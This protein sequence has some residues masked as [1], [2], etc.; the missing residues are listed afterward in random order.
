MPSTRI[1][2]SYAASAAP[3]LRPSTQKL[4][5]YNNTIEDVL[6]KNLREDLDDVIAYIFPLSADLARMQNFLDRYLNFPGGVGLDDAPPVYF[7]PAAPFVLLEVANYGRLSSN[8]VNA[9]WFSQREIAFG[10][11]VEWY[12]RQG[13][14]ITFLK[15]ALIYPYVYVDSPLGI[16]GGRQIYGWSKAPVEVALLRHDGENSVPVPLAPVFSPPGEQLLLAA[17]LLIPGRAPEA[18]DSRRRLIEIRQ[19][20]YLQ[21]ASSLVSDIL[22]AL[23]RAIGASLTTSWE[24]L[25]FILGSG[26]YVSSQIGSLATVLPQYGRL[27]AQF[28]PCWVT[29]TRAFSPDQVQEGTPT[30]IITFKQVRDIDDERKHLY[31]RAC[32]QGIVESQMLIKSITAGGSLVDATNPDPAAGIYIDL[33]ERE[34]GAGPLELGMHYQL[35]DRAP[36]MAKPMAD[37]LRRCRIVPFLPFWVKMNLR[38]G[39]AN[40]QTWRTT[41][42]DW[43]ETNSPEI[44]RE[45]L[46]IPY[47]KLGA[48]A[49]EEIP[50]PSQFPHLTMRILPLAADYTKIAELIG[51]YLGNQPY[52][53]HADAAASYFDFAPIGFPQGTSAAGDASVLAI[54]SNFEGMKAVGSSSTTY[55]D[56][57]FTFAVPVIWTN[58]YTNLRTSGIGLVPIYTFVG[59]AWNAITSAEVYGRW[60]LQ[61]T[62]ASAPFPL[63]L[64]PR[65]VA[66]PGLRICTQLFPDLDRTEEVL[67]LPVIEIA[68]SYASRPQGIEAEAGSTVLSTLSSVLQTLGLPKFAA[69][70]PG[71]DPRGYRFYGIA[72]K[73]VRDANDPQ[74]TD[75]Q[76]SVWLERQF[77]PDDIQW[78]D[79]DMELRIPEYQTISIAANLGL[80]REVYTPVKDEWWPHAKRVYRVRPFARAASRPSSLVVSGK[81]IAASSGIGWWRIGKDGWK[82]PGFEPA[83]LDTT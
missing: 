82:G 83:P 5:A 2:R 11:A 27:I 21:T 28:L 66:A 25:R 29:P 55:D 23:P 30:S 44:R 54:L 41:W 75:Y 13:E 52:V 43:T 39:L 58:N 17:N 14:S 62:F 65:K 50:A 32:Y 26:E 19:E 69:T 7:K 53:A 20:R 61:A 12:A 16:A 48:G 76:A 72:L 68:A 42:S 56:Y 77:I 34:Q 8:I 49:G 1:S 37:S 36:A 40:Y 31:D 3:G 67:D 57:E 46:D 9:G 33:F 51:N 81:L 59:T 24:A 78:L 10:M 45:P 6:P 71:A 70:Q 74:T 47:V 63:T 60:T 15:Y 79:A 73:Q 22:S 38:Y 4:A 64:P 35:V 80:K 18:D